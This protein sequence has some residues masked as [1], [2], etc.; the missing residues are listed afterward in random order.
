MIDVKAQIEEWHLTAGDTMPEG[1]LEKSRPVVLRGFIDD[2]PL[3]AAAKKSDADIQNQLLKAYNGKPVHIMQ[4][5]ASIKGRLFY[6]EGLTGFNFTRANRNLNE[7]FEELNALQKQVACATDISARKG[8][9]SPTIYIGSTVIDK[10]FA[11]L[12]KN[13]DLAFLR[14]KALAS[15][16]MGNQSRIAAHYDAPDNIACVVAG[17]RQF[18]LFPPEQIKNLYV[19]PIDYTPAGQPASLVDFHEPDFEKFPKFKNAIEH[20]QTATLKAGDAI[21]IPANWWHH[22]EALDKFNVL[23]NYWWRQVDDYV[24]A[25][26]DALLGAILSLRS[27]PKAQRDAWREI[28]NYYIFSTNEHSHIPEHAKGVLGDLDPTNSRK[29]RAMLLNKLNR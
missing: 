3:V 6:N 28:F 19:G 23:V 17:K 12:H 1:L 21:F 5:P 24:G 26:N 15:I 20:A 10:I 25:P 16:W 18:T 22:I 7:V 9:D 8:H 29:I 13:N 4:G 2:W 14:E 11:D 27:L